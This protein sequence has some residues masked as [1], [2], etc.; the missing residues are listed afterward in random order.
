MPLVA[1]AFG[2]GVII[3]GRHACKP[4]PITAGVPA[5]LR[6]CSDSPVPPAA[7]VLRS[8]PQCLAVPPSARQQRGRLLAEGVWC[9]QRFDA[10]G[11][12]AALG[13][14][15]SLQL[16]S[17]SQSQ[18]QSQPAGIRR[19]SSPCFHAA[20]ARSTSTPRHLQQDP[21]RPPQAALAHC[22]RLRFCPAKTRPL[23]TPPPI[24]RAT[25]LLAGCLKPVLAIAPS[26]SQQA[27]HPAPVTSL[28][29]PAIGRPS[30]YTAV[31]HLHEIL[32]PGLAAVA[33]DASHQLHGARCLDSRRRRRS[34]HARKLHQATPCNGA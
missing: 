20:L 5:C 31:D 26:H 25:G 12:Q 10:A 2:L 11:S 32:R 17:Q 7:P 23:Q 21:Q 29:P 1:G 34:V 22:C 13:R 19:W 3:R 6:A 33:A 4:T 15:R 28:A 30:P 9:A 14:D 8:V 16:P 18:S 24:A 27:H